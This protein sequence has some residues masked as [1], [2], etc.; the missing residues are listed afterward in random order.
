VQRVDLLA[1]PEHIA[2]VLMGSD[3]IMFAAGSGGRTKDDMTLLID[4]DG[5]V[6][7]MQAAEIAGVHRFMMISMLFA[8]DRNRWAEPLKSLYAA[9]FYADNWLVRQTNLAYTIVQPGALSFHPGTGKVKSDPLA[10]GS[11]PRA[12]LAAFMVAALHA[13]QAVGKTIPLIQGATP[14]AEALTQI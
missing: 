1:K 10:V 6:K 2:S 9:K 11:I 14:I 4:L 3:A 8:E 12:D 7:T 5:A 13:P